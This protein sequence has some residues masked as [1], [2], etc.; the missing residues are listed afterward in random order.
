[1]LE[2][3]PGREWRGRLR[4]AHGD[5][6]RVQVL[7]YGFLRHPD[8]SSSNADP[9]MPH[10]AGGDQRIH[11]ALAYRQ[12]RCDVLHRHCR[13]SRFRN[14]SKIASPASVRR[15]ILPASSRNHCY[16]LYP[17]NRFTGETVPPP[18]TLRDR[19]DI[20]G[21]LIRIGEAHETALSTRLARESEQFQAC[22]SCDIITRALSSITACASPTGYPHR[23]AGRHWMR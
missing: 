7:G 16:A 11:A 20:G 17:A 10:L 19:T 23:R 4:L 22:F 13:L 21:R 5:F 3:T 1:M 14:S 8:S 12:S 9:I 18:G 2:H 6:R 15:K